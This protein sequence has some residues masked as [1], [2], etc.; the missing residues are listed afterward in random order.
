[1]NTY[2]IF[3][4]ELL[5]APQLPERTQS[6]RLQASWKS[7]CSYCVPGIQGTIITLAATE[8][9]GKSESSCSMLISESKKGEAP[10]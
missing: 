6:R 9:Q 3:I 8:L 4:L 7:L 10:F 2:S 5:R 1:M